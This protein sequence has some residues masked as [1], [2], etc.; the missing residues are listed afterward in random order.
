VQI[1]NKLIELQRSCN[2]QLGKVKKIVLD[3]KA[4]NALFSEVSEI[5]NVNSFPNQGIK[6]CKHCGQDRRLTK[7]DDIEIETLNRETGGQD[8]EIVRLEKNQKKI[9]T[10]RYETI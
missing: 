3:E 1:L 6:M 4:Y 7:I 5:T 9:G 2:C 8:N 10:E